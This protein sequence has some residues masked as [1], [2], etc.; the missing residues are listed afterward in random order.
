MAGP[1]RIRTLLLGCVL[2]F[3]AGA[4]ANQQLRSS[5]APIDSFARAAQQ[6]SQHYIA[7]LNQDELE[8]AAING[9]VAVDDYSE[10]LNPAAYERLLT[11]AEGTFAGI[12]IEI[13]L[14]QDYFTVLH[15]STVSGGG[16]GNSG[17]R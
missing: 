6:I 4:T 16:I 11:D 2:A 12:G 10:L 8:Q 7:E 13:G 1:V 9:M 14:R 15:H 5:S 3:L 17:R